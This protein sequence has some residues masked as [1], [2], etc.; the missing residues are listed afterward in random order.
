[1]KKPR[2]FIEPVKGGYKWRIKRYTGNSVE[3]NAESIHEFPTAGKC[4]QNLAEY[5]TA[6]VGKNTCFVSR[7]EG[8]SIEARE[9]FQSNFIRSLQG[10]KKSK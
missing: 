3:D 6:I 5:L 10:P 7:S 9:T 8:P 1:M 4:A 2:Y